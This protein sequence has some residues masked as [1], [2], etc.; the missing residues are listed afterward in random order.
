MMG[1]WEKDNCGRGYRDVINWDGE[2]CLDTG[3]WMDGYW[4]K[5]DR[6]W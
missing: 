2:E 4:V 6:H 3:I 5:K 1:M